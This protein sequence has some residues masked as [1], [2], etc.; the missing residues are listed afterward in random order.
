ME[1]P[2]WSMVLMM[3]FAELSEATA[4]TSQL[5]VFEEAADDVVVGAFCVDAE[6]ALAAEEIGALVFTVEV[7][8]I[9][10]GGLALTLLED[11]IE[12]A[13]VDLIVVFTVVTNVDNLSVSR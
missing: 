4:I 11:V 6:E 9:F 8:D 5:L 3:Y 12:I 10:V 7:D 1:G 2:L 13:T